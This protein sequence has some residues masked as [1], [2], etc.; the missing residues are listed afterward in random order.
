MKCVTT[1]SSFRSPLLWDVFAISTYFTISL[2]F[3]YVGLVPDAITHIHW[4]AH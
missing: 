1:A 4:L 2:V 3:F